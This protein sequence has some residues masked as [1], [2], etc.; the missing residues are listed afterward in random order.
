[1][2]GVQTCALPI[3]TL[4]LEDDAAHVNMGGQWRIP[5]KDQLE[6]LYGNTKHDATTVNGVKGMIFTSKINKHQMFIPFIQGCLYDENWENW[7]QSLV[8]MWSSQVSGFNL[9]NAYRLNCYSSGYAYV[10]N[11]NRSAAFSVRGVFN[12]NEH[13]NNVEH[14][15]N[16]EHADNINM[17]I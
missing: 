15:N 14:T 3:S 16:D 1:M 11:Y 17:L 5:T 6:E 8:Y 4:N 13:K 2:T 9:Y 12:N 7:K 10:G